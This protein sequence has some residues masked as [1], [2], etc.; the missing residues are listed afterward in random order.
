MN[1]KPESIWRRPWKGPKAT[2]AWFGLL[3]VA[4]AL[5]VLVIVLLSDS[6]NVAAGDP[7]IWT[8]IIAVGLSLMGFLGFLFIRWLCCWPNFKRFLFVAACLVTLV[9]MAYAVENWRGKRAWE[10]YKRDQ[11]AK[12]EVLDIMSLAPPPVPDEQNFF[13]TPSWQGMFRIRRNGSVVWNDP[14][15]H[16]KWFLT[17]EAPNSE[18]SKTGD[19]IRGEPTALS[20]WQAY[21]R[22]PKNV[23]ESDHGK[24]NFFPI[25]FQPQTP[26][27]DVLMALSR[28]DEQRAELREGARRPHARFPILYENGYGAL[29]P[30]LSRMKAAN[31]YF[32]LSASAK[33]GLNHSE[34]A[35][36]DVL[37]GFRLVE[38]VRSEPILIS[39][40]VRMAQLQILLQPVWEGMAN[41]QWSDP[42]LAQIEETL[43]KMNF[44]SD[45]Q[46]AIRGE[47][48]FM[49]SAV[50]YLKKGRL[51]AF[52]E[53]SDWTFSDRPFG[54][55]LAQVCPAGW[56]DQNKLN[57]ARL[58]GDL[59]LPAADVESHRAFP[60]ISAQATEKLESILRHRTPYDYMTGIL[61]PALERSVQR[62]A[63]AQA[64]VDL[65]RVACALE[66]FRLAKGSYPE[67]LDALAPQF[68]KQVPHDLINGQPLKYRRTDDGRFILYSVGWNKTDDGGETG[69]TTNGN[70]RD[71]SRGDW[72]WRYTSE[73]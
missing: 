14:D 64:S 31:R 61:F 1:E 46:F 26:A 33:L 15:F 12:G 35:L 47:R 2:L 42:Q 70:S 16:K 37:L 73:D 28:F 67:S 69:M 45:Y 36:E 40:L 6:K 52:R 41:R 27:A 62:F 57:C 32:A 59:Y 50:D 60:E 63:F 55:V 3:A 23:F 49:N 44:L 13:A 72:V 5:V 66:R 39:H 65:A 20:E 51:K 30:H 43:S 48:A 18:M 21:F 19:W 24:T 22:G 53:I 4:V 8:V 34:A 54:A 17:V 25:A 10:N 29:L 11:E 58:Y 71:P 56:F 38:A 9:A 7:L 68:L